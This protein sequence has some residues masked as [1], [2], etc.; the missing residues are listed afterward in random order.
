MTEHFYEYNSHFKY[1]H[2]DSVSYTHLPQIMMSG[3][4]NAQETTPGHVVF[5]LYM[6]QTRRPGTRGRK[7]ISLSG[8]NL[9]FFLPILR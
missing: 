7:P 8:L 3:A 2:H 4:G 5:G 1:S 6:S 9:P